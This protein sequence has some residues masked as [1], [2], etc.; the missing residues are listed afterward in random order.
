MTP[1]FLTDVAGKI[2]MLSDRVKAGQ[3]SL[4]IGVESRTE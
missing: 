1:R 2:L 3:S 4:A